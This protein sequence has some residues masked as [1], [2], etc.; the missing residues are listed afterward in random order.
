MAAS[1]SS[2]GRA[3]VHARARCVEKLWSVLF[4]VVSGIACVQQSPGAGGLR[5]SC[6]VGLTGA[7]TPTLSKMLRQA[8]EAKC[9]YSSSWLAA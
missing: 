2:M 5:P 9:C 3:G 8:K 7:W 1:L 4:D 6:I